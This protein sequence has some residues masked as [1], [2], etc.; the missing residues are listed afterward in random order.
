MKFL[1]SPL[2]LVILLT[3]LI[4]PSYGQENPTLALNHIVTTERTE[5]VTVQLYF[6][7]IDPLG[8]PFLE[9]LDE[10][11]SVQLLG[12][13]G[14]LSAAN[15]R[16]P[17]E[18]IY[19]TMLLDASGSM[20]QLMPQVQV[21]AVSA[22]ERAPTNARFTVIQFNDVSPAAQ[23]QPPRPFTADRNLVAKDIRDARA[24]AGAPT[25]LYNAT[26]KAIE[27]L[28]ARMAPQERGAVILFTDGRD[29]RAN[30]AL[31]SNRTI[32]DVTY[33]A[34]GVAGID[35]SVHT[36]GLCTDGGCGNIDRKAL[37]DLAKETNGFAAIG[38]E[39]NLST[40]FAQIMEGL[41]S[42]WLATANVY[43]RQGRNDGV[44]K[45]R[46]SGQNALEFT[47]TFSFQSSIDTFGPPPPAFALIDNFHPVDETS[48]EFAVSVNS[49]EPKSIHQVI[50]Q[51]YNEENIRVDEQIFVLADLG[52]PLQLDATVLAAGEHTIQIKAVDQ[53]DNF[54]PDEE[55]K[56]VL[57]EWQFTH[58]TPP[59]AQAPPFTIKT[60]DV[61]PQQGTEGELV[62][63]L[64]VPEQGVDL[65]Y[66][67][68]IRIADGGG[69]AGTLART[70]LQGQ[71][72][73]VPLP[74]SLRN[75]ATETEYILH[76]TLERGNEGIGEEQTFPIIV[77]PV[78]QPGRIMRLRLWLNQNRYP[79]LFVF[80]I[81][82]T[83]LGWRVLD[84]RR[85]KRRELVIQRPGPQNPPTEASS[86][87]AEDQPSGTP[88]RKRQPTNPGHRL[89]LRII[90]S[91][92]Q[93]IIIERELTEFP[94][95]LGRDE[96]YTHG[97]LVMQSNKRFFNLAGDT[98][99]SRYHAEITLQD[100]RFL[101]LDLGS[102]NGTF[103]G[104]RQ[105]DSSQP[106]PLQGTTTI[107]LGRRTY[108]ELEPLVKRMG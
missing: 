73:R 64:D 26:D 57:A 38:N 11:G 29:E 101:L 60:V 89:L 37:T 32:E 23:L 91:P 58:K 68:Y 59:S 20:A 3:V 106:T 56:F 6:T 95:V 85:R 4:Q 31:C 62:I 65:I 77:Q 83:V 25:C 40:M 36:I 8:R 43:P 45:V 81:G 80:S 16:K 67:G 10:N 108:L 35:I 107:S 70:L 19:I 54:I 42:Q 86:L 92:T 53:Q 87:L 96:R 98:K 18:P 48:Y 30:G 41:N 63:N 15:V 82:L 71:Q 74:A 79:L 90:K 75:P 102:R 55:G 39:A 17:N 93:A 100:G 14:R 34:V 104:E 69:T 94:C 33:N 12:E 28:R 88:L 13:S 72:I 9:Q 5:D 103:I 97:D 46:T 51:V 47:T 66:E 50:I 27:L 84:E 1:L 7:P 49:S 22:L 44:L 78:T 52:R 21:A 99:V 24:E 2:I 61:L 105:L 76:L